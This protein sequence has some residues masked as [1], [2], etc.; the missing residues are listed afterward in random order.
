[1]KT[2]TITIALAALMWA[3]GDE[4][5]APPTGTA[6]VTPRGA[7]VT[8]LSGP[9]LDAEGMLLIDEQIQRVA[10][11]AREVNP[12]YV[13]P[14]HIDYRIELVAPAADCGGGFRI[15]AGQ[16]GGET[17][18]VAGQYFPSDNRI[19]TTLPMIKATRVVQYEGEHFGLRMN[20]QAE[21]LR[22]LT[23]T[24]DNP[25]PILGKE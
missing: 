6:T 21:Y 18:C 12:K 24:P 8:V 22:T 17:I 4:R 10:D 5:P 9:Q 23:H 3:C 1:M 7:R 15:P 14:R 11:V 2:L 25:H 13:F 19:R 20:D 16:Y